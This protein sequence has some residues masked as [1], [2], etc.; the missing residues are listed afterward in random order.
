METEENKSL[1]IQSTNSS[2]NEE[3]LS[4]LIEII[5]EKVTEIIYCK[6]I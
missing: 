2:V 5:L 4:S 1:T 3:F 6:H